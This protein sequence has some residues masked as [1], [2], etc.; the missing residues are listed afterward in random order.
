MQFW[1]CSMCDVMNLLFWS[2]HNP[3]MQ[4][5]DYSVTF[6]SNVK[7]RICDF[8]AGTRQR[9]S[10]GKPCFPAVNLNGRTLPH[11]QNHRIISSGT[12]SLHC[13]FL[14]W[15]FL[16]PKFFCSCAREP[17]IER[18]LRIPAGG[19]MCHS[20]ANDTNTEYSI[21]GVKGSVLFTVTVKVKSIS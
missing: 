21:V 3:Q 6:C 17:K 20:V 16:S 18:R 5:C 4:G 10:S 7:Q 12:S 2:S 19:Q 13:T 15:F 14:S 11:W 8:V 9:W 1:L